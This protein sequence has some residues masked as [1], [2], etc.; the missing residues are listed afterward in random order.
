MIY[1]QNLDLH[2]QISNLSSLKQMSPSSQKKKAIQ[3]EVSEN[4]SPTSASPI[5]V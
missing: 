3:Q 2:I 4:I 1:D 5:V